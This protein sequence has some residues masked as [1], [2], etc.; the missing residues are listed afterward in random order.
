M[1]DSFGV[2]MMTPFQRRCTERT[3]ARI[4]DIW[5]VVPWSASGS[6]STI[7]KEIRDSVMAVAQCRQDGVTIKQIAHDF[8]ISETCLQN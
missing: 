4:S 3:D 7:P 2:V 1:P 6:M 5:S 8:G